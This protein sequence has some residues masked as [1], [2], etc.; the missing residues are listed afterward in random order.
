[1]SRSSELLKLFSKL[2]TTND[3]K[4][5]NLN[6]LGT[7]PNPVIGVNTKTNSKVINPTSIFKTCKSCSYPQ[8]HHTQKACPECGAPV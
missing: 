7:I 8:V 1:M 3:D 4:N 2:N 6:N 5:E